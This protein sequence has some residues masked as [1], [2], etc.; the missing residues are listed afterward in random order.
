VNACKAPTVWQ[1]YDITFQAPKCEN[2]Q[3]V[4]PAVMTVWQN[5]T[6][7]QDHVRLVHKKGDKEEIVRNTTAGM[8]GDVCQPGPIMLQDHG[9][10][11]QY[12]N[13]WLVPMKD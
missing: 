1:T 9:H 2:G 12:R 7:I 6:L 13:I 4:E 5:D 8:G 3:P 11:V 10:P